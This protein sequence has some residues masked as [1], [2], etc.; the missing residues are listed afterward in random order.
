MTS[1]ARL[2]HEFLLVFRHEYDA[3]IKKI[4]FNAHEKLDN[5]RSTKIQSQI[6]RSYYNMGSFKPDNIICVDLNTTNRKVIINR[7]F[8]EPYFKDGKDVA[9]TIYNIITSYLLDEGWD[10]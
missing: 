6:N 1:L 2:N 9:L 10:I 4:S 5:F 3:W 8:Q 7:S